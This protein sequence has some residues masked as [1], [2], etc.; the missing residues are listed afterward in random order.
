MPFRRLSTLAVCATSRFINWFRLRSLPDHRRRV[1]RSR[2]LLRKLRQMDGDGRAP[3]CIA[4]LRR[5]DPL[6]FEEVV[7]SA[8]EDVGA[9]V[10]RSRRYTGDGGLDG[11]AW[12]S[13]MGWCAIQAKRYRFHIAHEHL[14]AF[15][16]LVEQS[17]FRAGLFVHTGRSGAA[18]YSHLRASRIVL[19]SGD[20]LVRLLCDYEFSR[21][22][23]R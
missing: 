4:Y 14:G 22:I 17:G 1:H 13:G 6:L 15:A 16:G 23:W 20:R 2:S 8:L 5:I 18:V 11:R 9:F 19:I 10:L 21:E 12:L 7:L 3:R